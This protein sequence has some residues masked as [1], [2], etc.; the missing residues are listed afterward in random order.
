[1]ATVIRWC[2][3]CQEWTEQERLEGYWLCLN[4]D[5]ESLEGVVDGD[6]E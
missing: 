6:Q 3:A 5:A 1:M 2:P 4:C